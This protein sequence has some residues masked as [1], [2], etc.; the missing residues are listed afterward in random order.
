[1][2]KE[3]SEDGNSEGKLCTYLKSSINQPERDLYDGPK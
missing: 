3:Q 1:M 2:R